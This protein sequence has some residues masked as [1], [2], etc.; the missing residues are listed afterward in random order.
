MLL[1]YF[2]EV[3]VSNWFFFFAANHEKLLDPEDEFLS[4]FVAPLADEN[5]NLDD[6]ETERLPLSLQYY[7]GKRCSDPIIVKKITEALYQV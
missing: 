5:D 2:I 3:T 4:A 7:D 6:D 1:C